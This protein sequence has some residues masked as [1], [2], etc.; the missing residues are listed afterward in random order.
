[1]NI[2]RVWTLLLLEVRKR[3]IGY[4]APEDNRGGYFTRSFP[5]FGRSGNSVNSILERY[6][7]SMISGCPRGAFARPD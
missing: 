6:L 1:M 3:G 7:S 5:H 2:I 4:G